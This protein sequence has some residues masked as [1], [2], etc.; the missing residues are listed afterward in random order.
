M[1]SD[2]L[3]SDLLIKGVWESTLSVGKSRA[4]I[5]HRIY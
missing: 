4:H 5:A 1:V 2:L 3:I